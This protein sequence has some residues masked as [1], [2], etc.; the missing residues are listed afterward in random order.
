M[1]RRIIQWPQADQRIIDYAQYIRADNLEAA[2]RF[3]D[4]VEAQIQKLA[5]MPGIGKPFG[6]PLPQLSGLRVSL[7]PDF[8]NYQVYYRELK[9]GGIEV[10]TVEHGAQDIAPLLNDLLGDYLLDE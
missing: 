8:P 7:V 3:I 6:S 1:S 2:V 5:Q 4:A 10:F 9:G